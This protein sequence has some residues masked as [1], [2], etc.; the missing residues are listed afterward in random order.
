MSRLAQLEKLH[1]IDPTDADVL[2][3]LAQEHVKAGNA[4]EGIKWYDRCLALNPDYLYAYYHK[5]RTQQSMN[6]LGAAVSTLRTGRARAQQ[7]GDA[8]ALNEIGAYLDELED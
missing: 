7:A 3:M 8:K 1:T 6:D 5:A 4:E 2:Y